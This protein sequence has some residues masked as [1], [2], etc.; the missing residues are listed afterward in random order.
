MTTTAE[1]AKTRTRGDV[2]GD[3]VITVGDAQQALWAYVQLLAGAKTPL[4]PA[5]ASAADVDMD[6]EIT[7]ADP[8]NI[9][10]YYSVNT[11]AHFKMSWEELLKFRGK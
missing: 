3:G 11:L 4:S 1:E 7:A 10:A 6:G 9:L 5:A 8:Q 2:D